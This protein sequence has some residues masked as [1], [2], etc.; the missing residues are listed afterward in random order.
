MSGVPTARATTRQEAR[1]H[2]RAAPRSVRR[3]T[4]AAL[5]LLAL[6]ATLAGTMVGSR[7]AAESLEPR[8]DAR[9][10]AAGIERAAMRADRALATALA[11]RLPQRA[12]MFAEP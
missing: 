2:L 9:L 12:T 3:R 10:I 7:D 4:S 6:P 8:G 1:K 11:A 5:V